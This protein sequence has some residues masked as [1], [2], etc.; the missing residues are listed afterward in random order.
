MAGQLRYHRAMQ[1]AE[2][3][4]YITPADTGR[5]LP[6]LSRV[7]PGPTLAFYPRFYW[8]VRR[9]GRRALRGRYGGNEW[10]E[11]SCEV[12]RALEDVGVRFELTG[13]DN[14][15]K[16]R[17]PVVLIGNHMSTL[18][19]MVLPCIIQPVREVTF[20]VKHS[21]IK[22]PVFGPVMRSRDPIV[23]GRV[24]PRDDF[25][26]VMEK[27]TEKLSSGVSIIVFPQSTRSHEFSPEDFNTLG[28]KLA[29]RAGVP[30]LPIALK[31]DAWGIGRP[32]KDFGPIDRAKKV[33]MKFGEPMVID[34]RGVEEHQKI[35]AF[36]RE[37][38]HTWSERREP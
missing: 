36:I 22:T 28:I 26:T 32:V 6:F 37:S 16:V 12:M 19:T 8:I 38:L 7:L 9:S 4:T 2:N 20:I 10:A 24:N 15:R 31:T 1:I 25:R 33:F 30:V 27:G 29:Q 21:L 17:G 34:G 23:V 35:I 13:M 11:S 18:E 3:D 5:K 14:L